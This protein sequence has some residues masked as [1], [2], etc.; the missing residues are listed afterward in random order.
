M[1]L[2]KI[3]VYGTLRKFLGKS[4]FEA[5]VDSPKDAIKFLICN[6]P[7]VEKHLNQQ[8]YK[9]KMGGVQVWQDNLSLNGK[10]DIQIIPVAIGSEPFTTAV[11]LVTSL[12]TTAATTAATVATTVATAAVT[13]VTAVGSAI[14]S[15]AGA[16]YAAGQALASSGFIGNIGMTLLVNTALSGVAS[17][18]TPDQSLDISDVSVSGGAGGAGGDPENPNSFPSLGFNQIQNVSVSG[19]AVPIIYGEV[20]TG[21]IVISAST[22]VQQFISS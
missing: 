21:S 5:A 13:T 11:S 10:G 7:K 6:F 19:G 4:Y 1:Q 12:V 14:A 15:G 18:L 16:I 20:F 17:L 2:K 22:D 3:K 9:I 8:V